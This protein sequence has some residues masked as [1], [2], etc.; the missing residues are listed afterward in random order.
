[1]QQ[2][3]QENALIVFV[4]YPEPGKVK[5]RIAK[6]LGGE[7]A[8]EI[9]SRMAKGVVERVLSPDAYSTVIY[10]DPPDRET[11][12]R[13]WLGTDGASFE[14]QSPGTIGDRMSDAFQRVFSEGAKKAVLIGTDVPDI[15]G[16]IVS[17][18]FGALG[19]TDVVLGP[20]EDGGYYLIGLKKND[21]CIFQDIEWG[22]GTVFERTLG[23]IRERNLRYKLLGVLKDVD[24]ADD[25]VPGIPEPAGEK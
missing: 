6:E 1:M 12:V 19:K 13:A 8:A 21:P 15:A 5:T 25:I 9:Y 4:K 2:R 3:D 14:P 11:D 24:T 16:E 7:K 22:T 17:A 18:A 23:L 20:S 10:F